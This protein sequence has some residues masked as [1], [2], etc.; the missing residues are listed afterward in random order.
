MNFQYKTIMTFLI[1]Y[2]LAC[3]LSA[4]TISFQGQILE[5][6]NPISGDY[7]LTFRI[8]D[9]EEGGE[10]LWSEIQ[11]V[12]FD[13]GV[14]H[15][16]LGAIEPLQPALSF[17]IA[18]WLSV[19]VQGDQEMNRMAISHGAYAFHAQNGLIFQDFVQIEGFR[20]QNQGNYDNVEGLELSFSITERANIRIDGFIGISRHERDNQINMRPSINNERWDSFHVS[21]YGPGTLNGKFFI[22]L[23]PGMYT[24]T[25]QIQE[26]GGMEAMIYGG[27]LSVQVFP[28]TT[29]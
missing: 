16:Q 15:V 8:Y 7:N 25:L 1:F 24:I 3:N 22:N 20:Y 13:N 23:D 9:Q 11:G 5:G 4:Q 19:Q 10:A 29:E 27:C 21:S 12:S 2:L 17:G 14:Y 28:I 6:E 18:Y 26:V